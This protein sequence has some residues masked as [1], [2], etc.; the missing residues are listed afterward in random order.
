M[1]SLAF[2]ACGT[3]FRLLNFESTTTFKRESPSFIFPRTLFYCYFTSLNSFKSLSLSLTPCVLPPL[4]PY[5]SGNDFFF[6]SI[7][8]VS[9]LLLS[10][11]FLYYPFSSLSFIFFL[12]VILIL[13]MNSLSSMPSRFS[14]SI[15][16][17]ECYWCS[18]TSRLR[19]I[20]NWDDISHR[21]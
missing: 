13:L 16:S 12:C 2:L 15:L 14:L 9:V 10:L 6:N 18:P 3:F 20:C 4:L 8:L 17:N 5:L 1:F 19:L 7:S 11:S 21:W